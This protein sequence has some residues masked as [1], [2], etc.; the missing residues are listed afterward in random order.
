MANSPQ[1]MSGFVLALLGL[2]LA[3][4]AAMMPQWRVSAHIGANLVRSESAWEGLWGACVAR[5][6]GE[7]ECQAYGSM[8]GLPREMQAARGLTALGLG[9]GLLAVAIAPIGMQCTRCAAKQPQAKAT[10]SLGSGLTLALAGLAIA[11][12]PSWTATTIIMQFHDP[13]RPDE[14]KRDLGDAL[15]VAW[16]AA[17]L[18]LVGGVILSL[19]SRS[20]AGLHGK[21]ASP[22]PSPYPQDH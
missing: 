7:S 12:P 11:G 9:L 10:L 2:A 6:S 17:A 8:L 14:M 5:T 21:F 4:L 20:P 18:L 15:F 16:S 13:N 1:Q 3:F 19:A 22:P